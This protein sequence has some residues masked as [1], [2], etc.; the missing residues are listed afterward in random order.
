MRACTYSLHLVVYAVDNLGG[1]LVSE[2]KKE[3]DLGERGERRQQ[4][5]G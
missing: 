4:W 1:L 5:F 3:G 2:G